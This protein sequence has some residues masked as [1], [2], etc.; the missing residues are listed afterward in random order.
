MLKKNRIILKSEYQASE[1]LENHSYVVRSE[2][3]MQDVT[4]FV[5]MLLRE[6]ERLG[7]SHHKRICVR[8]LGLT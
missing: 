8:K 6:T 1:G 4:R 7:R 5:Q 3:G 2:L